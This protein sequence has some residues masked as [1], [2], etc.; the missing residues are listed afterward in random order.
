MARKAGEVAIASTSAR[1]AGVS[2]I[3]PKMLS[4]TGAP[5]LSSRPSCATNAHRSQLMPTFLS[6][7]RL[8]LADLDQLPAVGCLLA[9]IKTCATIAI[10]V[11]ESSF[12]RKLHACAALATTNGNLILSCD[13]THSSPAKLKC[14]FVRIIRPRW[15]WRVHLGD[16][17]T[18]S[19]CSSA[20][21]CSLSFGRKCV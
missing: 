7:V 18:A 3:R 8:R 6:I 16:N 15:I 20:A 5:T 12:L 17:L 10:V 11:L 2:T 9:P 21:G 1:L 4:I 13:F 19:K 14:K